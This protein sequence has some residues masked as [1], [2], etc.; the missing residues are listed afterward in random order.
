MSADKF[1]TIGLNKYTYTIYRMVLIC[2]N[3]YLTIHDFHKNRCIEKNDMRDILFRIKYDKEEMFKVREIVK[4]ECAS[5]YITAR[6]DKTPPIK[7]IHSKYK[8][9][10]LPS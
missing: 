9:D 7:P 6:S 8:N 10:S 2:N 3:N 1:G 4:E 5:L